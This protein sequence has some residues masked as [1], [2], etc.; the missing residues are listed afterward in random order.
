[1]SKLAGMLSEEVHCNSNVSLTGVWG[2]APSHWRHWGLKAS[3]PAAGRFFVVF[4]EKKAVLT[5]LDHISYVFR[6]PF[7]STTYLTFESQVKKLSCSAFFW[8]L[9]KSKTRLKS[10]ML[11]LN[12]VSD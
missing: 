12:F 7:E 6:A 11:G 2:G 3:P 10:G 9:F 8:L 5:P 1:M 4:L